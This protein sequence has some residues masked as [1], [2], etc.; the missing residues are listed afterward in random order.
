MAIDEFF[1]PQQTTRLFGLNKEVKRVSV[2]HKL[3][4]LTLL[5]VSGV[6]CIIYTV[7]KVESVTKN[8]KVEKKEKKQEA[9][10]TLVEDKNA[11][12]TFS[13]PYEKVM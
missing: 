1:A 5:I 3:S 12:F 6:V 7:K 10:S 13:E 9:K 4:L 8:Q 11:S 2:Y